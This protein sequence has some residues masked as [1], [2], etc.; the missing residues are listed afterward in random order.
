MGLHDSF[1]HL[2]HKL[3]PKEGSEVKLAIW[4]PTIKSRELHRFPR[5][6]VVCDILLESSQWRIQLCFRPHFNRGSAHRVMGLQSYE[7]LSC[8]NFVTKW[9]LGDDPM[10]RHKVYYKGEGG[11]FPQIRAMLSFVNSSLLVIRPSSKNVRT[12]H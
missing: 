10:V 8:G 2:K 3:W 4:L 1:R 7:T 6:Q 11:G 9:H 12:K 5:V